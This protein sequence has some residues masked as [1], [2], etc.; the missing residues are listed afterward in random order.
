MN[1]YIGTHFYVTIN[2]I[3][4]LSISPKMYF[5]VNF[6]TDNAPIDT[7]LRARWLSM[8]YLP[9]FFLSNILANVLFMEFGEIIND[10]KNLEE[11]CMSYVLELSR[12]FPE[13]SEKT[14]KMFSQNCCSKKIL[15]AFL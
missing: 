9:V 7:D 11:V 5:S 1:E 2:P 15:G 3:S 12:Y 14:T 4:L 10:N 13:S 6:S 8:S